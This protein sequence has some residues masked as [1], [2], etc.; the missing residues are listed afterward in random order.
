MC[1][2][3]LVTTS[4]REKLWIPNHEGGSR[5]P[6]H[7]LSQEW[8]GIH[9]KRKGCRGESWSFT[10]WKDMTFKKKRKEIEVGNL[11]SRNKP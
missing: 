3:A 10:L 7:Y 9:R 11:Y 5:K 8:M 1:C 4:L 6:L 2:L